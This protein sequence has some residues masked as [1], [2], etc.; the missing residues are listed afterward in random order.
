[1]S[2]GLF[3]LKKASTITSHARIL[4][5]A[6]QKKTTL[7]IGTPKLKLLRIDAV[8]DRTG[9]RSKSSVYLAMEKYGLPRPVKIG[10]RSVA[11]QEDL[12]DTWI[13]DR[14]SA[15]KEA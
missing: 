8:M 7:E 11:W 13:E 3:V 5:H 9:L 2:F 12:I 6:R 4:H 15:S 14:I 10:D 1:M